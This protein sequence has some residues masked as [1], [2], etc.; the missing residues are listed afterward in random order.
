M[1]CIETIEMEPI[2]ASTGEAVHLP[3]GLLGFEQIKDYVLV[4]NVGE[5]PFFWLKVEDSSALAF[6]VVDPF[7]ILPDYRP[8]I[9]QVD[10]E[11]LG[12]Q[13]PEDACVLGIVTVHG[14]THATINL[15]GPVV[16]N[17]HTR[18]GKQVIIANAAHY[19]VQ[20]PLPVDENV[21]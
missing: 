21:V 4:S 16:M 18:I 11:F 8:D 15:K 20:Q 2:T 6:V 3:M 17:R 7:L 13:K 12:L 1:K 5:E 10:V 14:P 19:S 9:P